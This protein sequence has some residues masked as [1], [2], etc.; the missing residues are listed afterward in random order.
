MPTSKVVRLMPYRPPAAPASNL[1]TSVECRERIGVVIIPFYT[2][3]HGRTMLCGTGVLLQ[4]GVGGGAAQ[5]RLVGLPPNTSWTGKQ[6]LLPHPLLVRPSK[7]STMTFG[8]IPFVL[9]IES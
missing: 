6:Q 9:G 1:R 3:Q 4:V 5:R 7:L 8:R 2:E